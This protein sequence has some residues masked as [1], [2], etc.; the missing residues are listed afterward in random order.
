[1]YKMKTNTEKT[2]HCNYYS[3][4]K[5]IWSSG[6]NVKAKSYSQALKFLREQF[7]IEENQIIYLTCKN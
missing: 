4:E 7:G 3:N 2:Y 6:V 5:N 1:M